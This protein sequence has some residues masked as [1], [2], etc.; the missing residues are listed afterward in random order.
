MTLA[1]C[2]KAGRSALVFVGTALLAAVVLSALAHASEV[3]A[4]AT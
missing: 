2:A 1:K 3:C 4:L